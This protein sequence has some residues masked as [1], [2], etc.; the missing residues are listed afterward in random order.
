M[1]TGWPLTRWLGKLRRDPLKN[2]SVEADLSMSALARSSIPEATQIQRANADIAIRDLADKASIGVG[3]PW[4]KAIRE[5]SVSKSGDITDAL[6]QAIV[7]TDLGVARA[8]W[9]WRAVNLLQW[10]FLMMLLAGL[11]WLLVLAGLDFAQAGSPEPPTVQG[12]ALPTLMI[13]SGVVFGIGLAILSRFAARLS[14]RSK[15]K[16]A[17]NQLRAVIADVAQKQVVEPIEAELAAYAQ[18]REGLL[19]ATK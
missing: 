19:T 2:L 8:A 4:A 18:A 15:A 3:K 11:G 12:F 13:V 7:G 5:A 9:W 10:V 14:G 1:A 16:R 6:D 17:G